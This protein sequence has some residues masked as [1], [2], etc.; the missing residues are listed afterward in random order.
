MVAGGGGDMPV[1]CRLIGG[2]GGGDMP[3]DWIV[4]AGRLSSVERGL[5]SCTSVVNGR[6]YL[7]EVRSTHNAKPVSSGSTTRLPTAIYNVVISVSVF[8]GSGVGVPILVPPVELE[9]RGLVGAAG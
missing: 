6:A 9:A 7:A 1:I 3:T 2:G 8:S 5:I 4:A